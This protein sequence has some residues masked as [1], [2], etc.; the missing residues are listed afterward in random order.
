MSQNDPT[1]IRIAA[2]VHL[3]RALNNHAPGTLKS[4]YKTGC[5]LMNIKDRPMDARDRARFTM[6]LRSRGWK[7]VS[8]KDA[9]Y[10]QWCCPNPRPLKRRKRKRINREQIGG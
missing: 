5:K 7:A 10:A 9:K 2:K 6:F 1:I 3:E 4:L 8:N